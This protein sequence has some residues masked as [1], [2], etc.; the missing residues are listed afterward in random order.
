MTKCPNFYSAI[1]QFHSKITVSPIPIFEFRRCDI[2]H[3]SFLLYMGV[4][5]IIR[6]EINDA[7]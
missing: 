1:I 5:M 7:A 4:L 2:K 6:Q 3:W